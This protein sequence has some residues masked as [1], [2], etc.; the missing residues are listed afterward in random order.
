MLWFLKKK[1]IN[2]CQDDAAV[3]VLGIYADGV[4]S[5]RRDTCSSVFIAA[6]FQIARNCKCLNVFLQENEFLNVGELHNQI[7]LSC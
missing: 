7:L 3:S 6:L 5:Y 4:S 2:A 1:G